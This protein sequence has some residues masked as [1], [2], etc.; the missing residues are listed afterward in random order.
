MSAAL[1]QVPALLKS[2]PN[3]VAWKYVNGTKPPFVCGTAFTKHASSTDP[4]TWST[5]EK[6][7]ESPINDTEGVGFVL[8]GEAI[9]Q[10]LVGFDLDG[11]RNPETGELASWADEFLDCLESYAEYTPSG[12]GLRIWARGKL[13]GA[14]RVFKLDPKVGFGDKVQIEVY[15]SSR[16]FTIT[17]RAYNEYFNV[18]IQEIGDSDFS[19]IYSMCQDLHAKFPAPNSSVNS[20]TTEIG[21]GARIKSTGLVATTKLALFMTGTI[22]SQKPFVIED[23]KGNSLEYP[24]QSEADMALATALAIA[25]GDNA[26]L[27]DEEFRKSPLYREKWE[28]L[29]GKTIEKAIKTATRMRAESDSKNS[30]AASTDIAGAA[31]TATAQEQAPGFEHDL[32][33]QEYEAQLDQEWPVIKLKPQPGP[34]WSEDVFYGLSGDIIRK[35]SQYNEAHPAGML[36]DLLVALGSMFGRTC[37]FNTNATK[38]F[39]NEF[40]ARVGDSSYSRKGGG[41]DEIDR[42]LRSVDRSWFDER[43]LSGFGSSEAIIAQIKDSMVQQRFDKRSNQHVTTHVPGITDK[44]LCI[45]EGELASVFLLAGKAESR[46]DVIMRDGWDGKTLR[47]I[48]KGSSTD[49]INNSIICQEPHLSISGD[50]TRSELVAKMPDGAEENGFGNRFLYVYVYR[51]HLCPLGGPEIDWSSEVGKLY[52]VI[53]F[54]KKQGCV[55]LTPSAKTVWLRMYMQIENSRLSGLAGKMTSRAAAHI[56]RL[57]LIYAMLDLSPLVDVKHLRAAQLLWNYCEESAQY[58]FNGTTKSQIEL[59][60]WMERQSEPITLSTVREGFYKRNKKAEHI[61][62]ILSDLIRTKKVQLSGEVYRLTAKDK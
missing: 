22:T 26:E 1:Q 19:R 2:I 36:M 35:A 56:R 3:W 25:H 43:T 18:P 5:Y 57:A 58:I 28:R 37:Y 21:E 31:V 55:G 42:L 49:G 44:R 62:L 13:P 7:S 30:T 39:S 45:R 10:Q 23:G 8:G 41:R 46:A 6:A 59:L 38:H 9:A 29:G 24:S 4:A 27:I 51:V 48:V 14:E 54:A 11:C 16:Y 60:Q 20:G 34:E 17:G 32:T 12:Y 47:N 33:E 40:M 15:D 52:D 61:K 53:E 50:T